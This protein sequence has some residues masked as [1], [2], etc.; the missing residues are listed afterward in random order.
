MDTHI[1]ILASL[2]MVLAFIL[3][4][5]GGL[6]CYRGT[7]SPTTLSIFG[8]KIKTASVGLVI[9]FL[10]VV[11]TISHMKYGYSID[12]MLE[13]SLDL[14]RIELAHT[15]ARLTAIKENPSAYEPKAKWFQEARKEGLREEIENLK[16]II[17]RRKEARTTE[18]NY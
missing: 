6:V 11:V 16:R 12:R 9:I 5:I 10:G 7:K 4:V 8:W 2:P 15:E 18:G 3:A 14:K 17:E 13:Y 1:F